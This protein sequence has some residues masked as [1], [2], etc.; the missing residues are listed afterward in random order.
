VK[1]ELQSDRETRERSRIAVWSLVG[2]FV[3]IGALI[4]AFIVLRN[5]TSP[6][7]PFGFFPFFGFGWILIPLAFFG[8]FFA[9]RWFCWLWGWGYGRGYYQYQDDA[10][11]ILRERY[12]KG[13]LTKEQFKQMKLDLESQHL[14]GNTK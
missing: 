7:S 13:Q 3:V 5:T 1:Q 10:Q 11:E 12:A 6:T 9:F 8:V 4:A 14:G 2:L